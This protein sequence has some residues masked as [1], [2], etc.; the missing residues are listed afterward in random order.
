M[1]KVFTLILFLLSFGIFAQNEIAQKVYERL[2]QNVSFESYDVLTVNQN[3]LNISPSRVV[4]GATYAKIKTASIA[5][6]VFN[7]P[8]NIAIEIPYQGKI[9]AL[10]LYRVNLFAND[11]HID[12]N[13][14]NT[15]SYQRGVYYRGIVKGDRNSIASFNFFNNELNGVI[16]NHD[17][18]N[19]NIGKLTQKGNVDDY[20]VYSDSNLKLPNPIECHAK[21][22]ANKTANISNNNL[23]ATPKCVT[24]YFEIDYDLFL[25]NDSN[26][27]TT[28]NWATSVFNNVQT[29]FAN[30][31]ITVAIKSLYIWTETDPYFGE[32]SSDYLFQFHELRPVFDGDVGQLLGIDPGGLGGVAYQVNGLCSHNNFS[33]SDLYFEYN[34]LP[35]FSWDVFVISH[36]LGHLLGSPHTHTCVWNGNNTAIDNCGPFYSAKVTDG[37]ECLTSPPTIPTKEVGGT[38]MSY[39]HL[40]SDVGVNFANG[41]GPQPTAAIK[42]AINNQNCLS[43]DCVNTCINTVYNI[44]ATDVASTSALITWDAMSSD[45]KWQ[46]SITPFYEAISWFAIEKNSYLVENLKPNTFYLISIRPYCDFG[47]TAPRV[48]GSFVTTANFCN[49]ITITDSG[50]LIYNYSNSENY[51]RT[52]IPNVAKSKIK[53]NFTN[54]DLEQ[55]YDYLYLYDGNSI[56]ANDLSNGGFT[57]TTIPGSFVS[58]AADGSLTLEFFSDGFTVGKGYVAQVSCDNNLANNAFSPN[59]DFTYF[60]NPSSG[61]VTIASKTQIDEVVVYNLQGR[62]LYKNKINALDVKVDM[63]L[64]SKGTYFFKLKFAEKEVNFK[65]LK[66]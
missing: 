7:K 25:A 46:I 44:K 37:L 27:T 63:T 35:I 31:G 13:K 23:K 28:A 24:V 15:I 40:N 3:P 18:N 17:F 66:M 60:P 61:I 8:E 21:D 54:F 43:S 34:N 48:D 19:L 47:L 9:I 57:G 64:F 38:I 50:G 51:I 33:Y 49:G 52:I 29:I 22:V 32:D 55:D 14:S 1:K 56:N 53:L 16:S 30:D 11:F 10:Q 45:T 59:I 62:L 4:S 42:N 6:I 5:A 39:C 58:T 2:S 12:S 65:I 41:F 36:E 26:T 20:I